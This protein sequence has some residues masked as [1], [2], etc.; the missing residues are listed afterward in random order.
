MHFFLTLLLLAATPLLATNLLAAQTPTGAQKEGNRAGTIP[1]WTGGLT[2]APRGYQK[3]KHHLDPFSK[4]KVLFTIS[5]RNVEK[6]KKNLTATHYAMI[7]RFPKTFKMNIYKSRRSCALPQSVYRAIAQNAKTARL[8][9]DGNSVENASIG[10]P[11]PNPKNPVEIYWNHNFHYQGRTEKSQVKSMIVRGAD[12]SYVPSIRKQKKLFYYS[13][14]KLAKQKMKANEHFEWFAEY[15]APPAVAG[16]MFS[17]TNTIDQVKEFRRGF[18]Y[19]VERRRTLRVPGSSAAYDSPMNSYSGV[20]VSDDLFLFNGAPDKYNWKLIG[21][22]EMYIPYNV[23]KAASAPE[24]QLITPNHL[25]QKFMRYEL[26]RVWV[27]EAKLK[28]GMRHSYHRR[29][30]YADEDSGIF[31]AADIYDKS[32]KLFRGQV[33]FIKNY[34]EEP[35]CRQDFE[36]MY[37]FNQDYYL[38]DNIK[39]EYGPANIQAKVTEN[40][41][42]AQA[43]RRQAR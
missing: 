17:F 2:K 34:Y 28:K 41:F 10:T 40:E 13:N 7:K 20:R 15:V 26:H 24:K 23:Y 33:G 42:G 8:V 29:V 43:L 5:A 39:N 18:V 6:Y 36:A 30:F 32:N 19:N 21:K 3:G 9:K 11:F 1:A 31:A 14:P 38:A 4:D 37:Y 22:K 12:G 35:A 25:N 27:L 16:Q